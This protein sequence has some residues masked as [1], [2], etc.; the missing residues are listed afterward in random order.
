[1][2]EIWRAQDRAGREVVLRLA[3]LDHILQEHDEI[4]DRSGE[5]QKTIEQPGLVTR[6]VEYRHRENHYRRTPSQRNGMK[7]VVQYRPVPPAIMSTPDTLH[8]PRWRIEPIDPM[9]AYVA[10]DVPA[11][12][13]LVYFDGKPVPAVSDPLDAPGF[14]G[15]AIMLGVGADDESTDEIVGVQVI[16][17]LLGAVQQQPAW[18]VLAWAAMAGEFGTELLKERL[19]GFL[20]EVNDAFSRYWTPPPSLEEQMA[21]LGRAEK[22]A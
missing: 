20:A 12:E 15:V 7:V 5:V 8:A 3:G 13:F 16:P 10:Y 21:G 1:L 9:L 6:D 14:R 18:A 19:P 22:T 17:M 2:A 4:A 11:D